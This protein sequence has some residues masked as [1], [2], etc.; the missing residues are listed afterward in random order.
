MSQKGFTLI[1]LMVA[2]IIIAIIST[3]G[4]ATAATVLKVN[5][6]TQRTSDLKLIQVAL[7]QYYTDQGYFPCSTTAANGCSNRLDLLQ[8]GLISN[9][10]GRATAEACNNPSVVYMSTIPKDPKQSG[11]SAV[12]YCY[13][14]QKS[15][16]S[17]VTDPP[18]DNTSSLQCKYYHLYAV[19]ELEGG[20]TVTCLEG[21]TQNNR[22]NFVVEPL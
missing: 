15:R 22:T 14:A 17:L 10:T 4:V 2:M 6:N 13:S 9:C 5:R 19:M 1:E 11:D 12:H 3:V 7:Q 18:C 20:P 8:G 21:T 16:D